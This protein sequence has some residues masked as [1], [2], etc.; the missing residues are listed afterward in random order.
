MSRLTGDV[1]GGFN[2]FLEQQKAQ[3]GKARMSVILFDGQGPYEV[4]VDGRRI[5]EVPALTSGVYQARGSTPLFDALG[6]LL[7]RADQRIARRAETGRRAESVSPCAGGWRVTFADGGQEEARAL[8]LALPAYRAAEL[9]TESH[10][11]LGK[12]LSSISYSSVAVACLGYRQEDV[13]RDLDGYGFLVPASEGLQTLGMI[14]TSSIYPEHAP[15]G[16]VSIRAMIGGCRSPEVLGKTDEELI[17]SAISNKT[18]AI[19]IA[20]TPVSYTH[21]T[22]P[23]ILLV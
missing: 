5:A 3:P 13:E 20:H 14:W 10:P 21:L 8:V 4:V 2:E 16:H 6:T 15:Q 18:K 22:L 11:G 1:I 17:E 19:M 12:E 7:E 23:T 9:F